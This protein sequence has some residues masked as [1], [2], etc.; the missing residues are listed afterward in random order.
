MSTAKK[1]ANE[2][3]VR[4]ETPGS[5]NSAVD[6]VFR[7]LDGI[8]RFLASLKL[9]VISLASLAAVLGYATFFEKWYGTAAVQEWIYRGKPFAVLLAFL[10]ANILCAALIRFPWKKRQI[11]FVVTHAGLLIVIGG[12]WWSLMT[13]DEG[14]LGALEGET[15][16]ELVRSDYPMVRVR[17]LDPKQP[18]ETV[19]EWELPFRP[20]SFAWGPGQPREETFFSS[21][22][23]LGW[24]EKGDKNKPVDVLTT[25][26]DPFQFVV[27]SHIPASTM[28]VV[29]EADPSG[30][31][32]IELRPTF[33]APGMEAATDV[34]RSGSDRWFTTDNRLH[35][36]VK[37]QGPALFAFQYVDNPELVEEFLNP[38]V[39]AGND[40]V[41]QF[42]YDD[43]DGKRRTFDLVLDDQKDK[44][45]TLPDSDI[46]VKLLDIVGFP[47][48]EAGLGESLGAST[49]PIAE[50]EVKKGDG[51]AVKHF[52]LAS[53]PM[54]PNVIP[55]ASPDPNVKPQKAI[56]NLTYYL[57]PPLDPKGTGLFGMVEVLGTPEGNLYY[58]VFGRPEA[59]SGKTR[60]VVRAKGPLKRGEAI[61]AFGGKPGGP[62][63]MSIA[64]EVEN[65][66][67][68]GVER[69][70]AEAIVIPSNMLGEAIAASEVE[71]TVNDPENPEKKAS[72]SFFIRRSP[73][74]LEQ[75]WQTVRVGEHLYQVSYDVDRKPLGFELKLNDFDVGFDP[76]TEQASRFVSKVLLTD[77]SKGII[78][79]P[80]TISMNEPL[81]HRGYTFYQSRYNRI[82]DPVTGRDTGDFQSIF[83]VGSDP[84][85]QLKYLGCLLVV[86]GAFLQFYM[87]AG[88]FTDG[89][90]RE[91][92]KAQLTVS[93]NGARGSEPSGNG[94]G[95]SR[96]V[97]LAVEDD[98]AL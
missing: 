18:G 19:R 9:A 28:S 1:K 90:K 21:L 54:F 27:K 42:R 44:V 23:P 82:K 58:R 79:E 64:F 92:S 83:Q 78:D 72:K 53:L 12:S 14:N 73:Q 46:T 65:Y 35:R 62:I 97:E 68:K 69:D 31:P 50:F 30:L 29:H 74:P 93:A 75:A 63:P 38:P 4:D 13:A 88:L 43:M 76:G 98:E 16:G 61:T 15:K 66:F 49:I 48:A 2:T 36:V 71:M 22:N 10:G 41:G 89:G 70:V 85:R 59:G 86:L 45:V 84:G 25:P 60:G 17:E 94:H 37:S 80:H 6:A 5:R 34:F 26:K 95:D 91:R 56:V 3:P 96:K 47:A 7:L 51:P 52:G 33:K 40:G 24:F 8:Y 87:R 81:T 55:P 32:M 39:E 67:P 77:T 20:G 57:P 11:G